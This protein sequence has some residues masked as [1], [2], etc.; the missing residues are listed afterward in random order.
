MYIDEN[1]VAVHAYLCGDGYVIKNPL[2][3][4]QKYYMIG[5]RNTS[6]V[7]LQDFQEKFEAIFSKRPYVTNEG[8]CRIGSKEIYE[9]LTEEFGSFYSYHWTAPE[10][11]NKFSKIWL[12]AFFD[13]EGWV[14]CKSHQNRCIGLECVNEKGIFQIKNM[15]EKIGVMCKVK[16]RN[17][18]NIFLLNI[19]GRENLIKFRDEI[20]FLHPSKRDKLR[21]VLNDFV[22]YNWH[23]PS[24]DKELRSFIESVLRSKARV[25][26]GNGV[27]RLISNMEENLIRLQE[28]LMNLFDIESRIGMRKNGVGTVYFEMSI[29]K[30]DEVRK[31][32]KR[33]LLNDDEKKKWLNLKKSMM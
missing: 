12:R 7:L 22:D 29:N 28:G 24:G 30:I 4:K 11:E 3:Q 25:K 32:I 27:V 2:T 17:T 23:F 5:F 33:G 10:L 13:C 6:T 1:L 19:F 18:K 9:R 8:R 20:N 26:K 31:L 15:L 16:K 14:T 21:E